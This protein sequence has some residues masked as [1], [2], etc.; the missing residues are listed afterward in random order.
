M[1]LFQ[2]IILIVIV[3]CLVYAL[4]DR[5]CKCIEHC[6]TARSF[7][8]FQDGFTKFINNKEDKED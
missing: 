1:G 6:T 2:M 3:Y 7:K 4:I 8:H 5:I